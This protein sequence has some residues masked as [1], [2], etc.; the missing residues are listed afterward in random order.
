MNVFGF[1]VGSQGN[2]QNQEPTAPSYFQGAIDEL[3]STAAAFAM[4][5]GQGLTLNFG[6]ELAAAL[7]TPYEV[8]TTEDNGKGFWERVGD[9]YSDLNQTYN[10]RLE[11]A[12]AEHP[13]ASIAGEL[14]GGVA[15]GLAAAPVASGI[16]LARG[17]MIA[18][19]LATP[20]TAAGVGAVNGF[21]SG[22]TLEDRFV[23]AAYG[24][25][26]GGAAGL[27]APKVAAFGEFASRKVADYARAWK[28]PAPAVGAEL[29]R[30]ASKANSSI[31]ELAASLEAAAADGQPQFAV[32]DALA[33]Y[34]RDRLAK[35]ASILKPDAS[36]ALSV[37]QN[38]QSERLGVQVRD[39][40]DAQRTAAGAKRELV[41]SG[42]PSRLIDAVDAGLH[43]Q[44]IRADP[45]KTIP[46]YLARS[47]D[48][49]SSFR[50]GY[51]D[52][53]LARLEA[54]AGT[55]PANR[56]SMFQTERTL[57]ELPVF[58]SPGK[59]ERLMRQIGREDEMFK[60]GE[61][62]LR[63]GGSP[64]SL[65]FGRDMVDA[66]ADVAGGN[67]GSALVRLGSPFAAKLRP[68]KLDEAVADALLSTDAGMLR[69]M[70]ARSAQLSN[71]VNARRARIVAALVGAQAASTSEGRIFTD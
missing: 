46:D 54:S 61:Q 45:G 7:M 38:S 11:Q 63:A 49:Q 30:L 12:R 4:H 68:Q 64:V 18:S 21:G 23:K 44:G 55:A 48:E 17:G 3:G 16:G 59:G 22:D 39:A 40:F 34:G 42:A 29:G 10:E 9:T 56:A 8:M 53:H 37:R 60:T 27:A 71:A 25:I 62:V 43:A 32:V 15:L 47:A 69:E 35:L 57:K 20:L 5:A 14:T 1:Q 33:E 24:T 66:A 31:E 26:L 19:K 70:G 36:K 51:A 41:E 50:V 67:F 13:Y 65:D 28:N 2:L 6:D 58:A 52:P